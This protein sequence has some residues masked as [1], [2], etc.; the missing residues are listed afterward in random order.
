MKKSCTGSFYDHKLRKTLLKMKL[1]TAIFFIFGIVSMASQGYAQNTRLDISLKDATIQQLIQHIEQQSDFSFFY[2]NDQISTDKLI[3]LNEKDVQ[4]SKVLNDALSGTNLTYTVV[5]KIIVIRPK[6]MTQA[7][8]TVTGTVTSENGEPLPGVNIKIKGTLQGTI[9]NPDGKYAIDVP[10]DA[11][12]VFS[13]VGYKSQE[14]PVDGK[15]VINVTMTEEAIGLQEVV[16]VGYGTQKKVN[17]TGAVST[18]NLD[19]VDTRPI[20][21]VSQALSGTTSGVVVLQSDA[22]PGSDGATMYVRGLNT[23][24]NTNPLVVI[25]G[26]VG[27]ISEISPNDIA[28]ISVLK[29]ASASAIY[30]A[31]AANGVILITTKRGKTGKIKVKYDGYFGFNKATRIPGTVSNSAT[32]MELKNEFEHNAGRNATYPDSIINA[33]RNG[34]DPILYANTDWLNYAIGGTGHIQSH[35][36][37]V[38]GGTDISRIRMS[39][40][41]FSETG[42]MQKTKTDYYTFRTNF[43]SKVSKHFNYGF[44]LYGR[45]QNTHSPGP[46]NRGL[47]G[48]NYSL[49]TNPMVVPIAP[50]GRYGGCQTPVDINCRNMKK[51]FDTRVRETENQSFT[52][53]LFATYEFFKG[54]ALNVSGA[55]DYGNTKQKDYQKTWTLWN[56]HTNTI[57]QQSGPMWLSDYSN[58]RYHTTLYALL[59]FDHTFAS[60]HNLH[61]L[62]GY[63]QEYARWDNLQ[64]SI[65][66]FANND[67]YELSAGLDVKSQKTTGTASEW[68][69]R[70]YFGR[71]N[72]DYKGKY[73]LEANLRYDGSSR[74]TPDGRWGLFPSFSAGWRMSE[75]SFMKNLEF[76]SNMKLRASW[77]E[78]GNNAIGNYDYIPTYSFNHN[79]VFNGSVYPGVAITAM[80]E[81]NIKWETTKVT[82][83]GAD[84]GL[85]K[86]L[87]EVN[88]DYFV[89]NTNDILLTVPIPR[90]VGN[91]TPPVRNL[92]IVQ[93]KGWELNIYHRNT[94]NDFV[95]S[96]GLHLSH[97]KNK[98]IK[99]G[100]APYL[101]QYMLKEGLPAYSLY[102]YKVI[103]I[104]QS[105]EEVDNAPFQNPA[106]GPG[107]LRFEDVN[108][109]NKI[110]G[111]DRMVLGNP[112]PK[113]VYGLDFNLSWKGIDFYTLFQGN[114]GNKG[115]LQGA[116]I[117]PFAYGNTR[118]VFVDKW[119]DR[120]TPENPN[121]DVPRLNANRLNI[122][123]NSYYVQNESYLRIKSI[124]LGYTIPQ[125]VTEKITIERIRIYANVD[126][127]CVF[128][129]FE[130][131]DP[132]RG[133]TQSRDSYP[134][135]RTF[136]FGLNVDF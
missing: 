71:L 46:T 77:G 8:K 98:I 44:N 88:F 80:T 27:N 17:L 6:T 20:T 126:N 13:F 11:I 114:Y 37:T 28:S 92:G 127:C 109:D 90:L 26:I 39:A 111:D 93:N 16:T 89:K 112:F 135:H 67:L 118:G 34:T 49:S 128:T 73:L 100:D 87:L 104:F 4:I 76:I 106:T 81:E 30:G 41:Y 33:Y 115:W 72:Y 102:G 22:Q 64:G 1:T 55:I 51:D 131:F 25:D 50:D 84:L 122:G 56:F 23:L 53:K 103:G 123:N 86:N 43:N 66:Q 136:T 91:L 101:G 7:Q 134:N 52:S 116:L 3:S 121:T 69:L 59:K 40:G 94:V 130:G 36:F 62:A 78:V 32:Y 132:E 29:D 133:L 117:Y 110:D 21:Q 129:N 48:A 85:F 125:K 63:Q 96:I 5:D 74:F 12:L 119:L 10:Q 9:T 79:Y 54:L 42:V 35:I 68:A 61:I 31:R 82:D 58:R 107:D 83:I 24:N 15:T 99:Y 70:S 57:D 38:T 14:I 95:Y 19:K 60:A 113:L 65:S 120:W 2:K 47:S 108:N 124:Q 97:A 75:E 18:V 45:W 105:Q